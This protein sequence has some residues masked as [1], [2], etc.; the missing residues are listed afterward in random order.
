[1]NSVK[2]QDT[3]LV[4]KNLLNLL[5][6]IANMPMNQQCTYVDQSL[7]LWINGREQVDDMTLVGIRI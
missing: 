5:T 7:Q 1:M 6:G 3:K 2:L 4:C